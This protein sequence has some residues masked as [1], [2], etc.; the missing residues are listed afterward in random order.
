MKKKLKSY[1]K[2][3]ILKEIEEFKLPLPL[4][5]VKSSGGAATLNFICKAA[6]LPQ[7]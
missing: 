3:K 7:S 4:F 5:D 2:L 6:A 1:E